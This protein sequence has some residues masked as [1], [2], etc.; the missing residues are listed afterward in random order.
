MDRA[1]AGALAFLGRSTEWY[2]PALGGHSAKQVGMNMLK[3]DASA[4][5]ITKDLRVG[6]DNIS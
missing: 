1:K 3:P 2:N 4:N 5:V 6:H